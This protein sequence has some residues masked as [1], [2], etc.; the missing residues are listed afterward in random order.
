[1]SDNP[2]SSD[3]QG[4]V[5]RSP[6]NEE[7]TT[8]IV[9][10]SPDDRLSLLDLV[11]VL[12]NQRYT[13]LFSTLGFAALAVLLLIIAY[14]PTYTSEAS[15]TPE[16]AR[17]RSEGTLQA[18]AGRFGVD[19]SSDGSFRSPEF[20]VEFIDSRE[21]LSPLL[22]DTFTI[23][24]LQGGD[25]TEVSGTILEILEV[26]GANEAARREQGL[27]WLR[28]AINAESWRGPDVVRISVTT[29]WSDLS[30]SI[31]SRLLEQIN[32]FNLETR[33]SQ[34]SAERK[35]IEERLTHVQKELRAAEER[36]K[37][38]L[39]Q[40]RQFQNSPDLMFEHERLQRQV[41]MQQ[42]VYTSLRQSFEEARIS[43]VRNTPMI[44]VLEPAEEPV[45]RD[46]RGLKR[47]GVLGLVFGFVVGVFLA[48]GREFVTKSGPDE[49]EYY[50][51]FRDTWKETIRDLQ[52]FASRL[53]VR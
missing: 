27:S 23:R 39:E 50:R 53:G 41:T 30:K 2:R 33:R 36:L 9:R 10:Y 42:Q 29:R 26:E 32:T 52:Q 4:A 19:V 15:F 47:R 11:R 20:Y 49:S 51:V 13:V 5:V 45:R 8:E 18:V 12:L 3:E 21:I 37:R 17:Q 28:G 25:T 1:M 46:P 31:A 16:K 7:S 24:Q 38:F 44:T 14:S 22:T 43:E 48:F 6:V 40:N 35:F 34:A